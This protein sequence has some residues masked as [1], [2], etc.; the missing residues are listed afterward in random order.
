MDKFIIRQTGAL[1]DYGVLALYEETDLKLAEQ[2]M[3]S[4]IK[5][6][7]GMVKGDPENEHL[8]LMTAQ[9][10]NGF[11]LGFVEDEEP[12][13]AKV[14]Y[15]RAKE[16]GLRVLLQD[17]EFS[18][19]DSGS[20]EAY[21]TAVKNLDEEYIDALF[22][23]GFAWAG[24]INLSIDDPRA[25]IDLT[26]VQ[27]LMERVLEIDEKYFHG[28]THLFF[29]SIWGVKPKM[30]GGDPEKAKEH[31]E[32]NLEIT[33]G[34]FL[35]TYV[36]Y[37]MFYAAKVLDEDLFYSFVVKIEDTPADVLPG[38]QLLNMIAKK[39]VKYLREFGAEWF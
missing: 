36:Y 17:D 8:L 23:T 5:L 29:G 19:A 11:A 34:K 37:A 13:R 1:L 38:F 35:L 20:L 21:T 4:D 24:W 2:A 3:A 32:K 6:L 12:E 30:L 26:K 22:W 39:K 33:E 14:F 16:Y 10:L 18:E 31:F 7:E 9:A 28:A 27:I 25:M 15:L